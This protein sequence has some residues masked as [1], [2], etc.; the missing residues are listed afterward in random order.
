MAERL[1]QARFPARADQLQQ[2]RHVVRQALAGRCCEPEELDR[3]VLAVNEACTNVIQHA[4]G[5]GRAGDIILDIQIDRDE[6][7]F[8]LTDFAEPVEESA[9]RSRDLS[10][11][12]PGGLGVHLIREVMDAA[13]FVPPPQG[14]GNVLEMRK[15]IQ[16]AGEGA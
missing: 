5:P 6:L 2:M 16:P 8:R 13:G 11:I 14:A 10:D 1:A 4:Y 7:I 12:R 15:R 3:V 9:I